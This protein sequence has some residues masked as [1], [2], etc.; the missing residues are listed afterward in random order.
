MDNAYSYENSKGRTYFLHSRLAKN[1]KTKL[2]F[3]AREVKD[4]AEASLPEG[5]EVRETG[6]GEGAIMASP[7]GL[8][9]LPP[10]ASGPAILVLHP[11]WG[12]NGTIKAFCQRLAND[13]FVVL[14]PDLYHGEVATTIDAA[15]TLS[16]ALSEDEG[17][18]R[19]EIDAAASF[20]AVQGSAI[21]VIGFSMGAYYAIE[22]ADS[23]PDWVAKVVLFYGTGELHFRQARAS[24]MGHFAADD[25]YE[26]AEQI[27][28]TEA[29]IRDA[30]LAVTFHRYDKVGHWFFEADR[31]DAYDEPSATLAW[32]RTLAFLQDRED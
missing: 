10:V 30:G 32:Q 22:L 15:E 13:G 25:P 27:A 5:Y 21:A 28:A 3:F 2:Y 26:S 18:A 11:W 9:A 24:Y 14:A 12:L 1:S 8:F 16:A 23:R 6:S 29:A 4:G 17:R 20:L 31:A 7:V 19:A